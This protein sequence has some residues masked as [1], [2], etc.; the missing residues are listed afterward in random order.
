MHWNIFFIPETKYLTDKKR[1][2]EQRYLNENDL[3][4]IVYKFCFFFRKS[5][6]FCLKMHTHTHTSPHFEQKTNNK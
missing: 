2:Q 6:T 3:I 1:E 5:K 4:K